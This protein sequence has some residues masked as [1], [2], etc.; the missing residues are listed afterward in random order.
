M[1]QARELS[2][3]CHLQLSVTVHT[4]E[5]K[6][7]RKEF[8]R[9]DHCPHFKECAICAHTVAVAYKVCKLEEF[10][11]SF[12]VP[13]GQMVQGG[14]PGRSWMKDNKRVRKRKQA[15]NPPRDVEA[16][17]VSSDVSRPYELV[18][19]KDITATTCYGCKGHVREKPVHKAL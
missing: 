13:I 5:I 11:A 14:I 18:F 3:L 16:C 17:Q 4:V 9:D 1:M 2:Y 19:V 8:A 6:S 12:A 10:V 7:K 15:G